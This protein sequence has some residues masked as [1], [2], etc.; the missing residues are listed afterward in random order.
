MPRWRRILA[1]ALAAAI[2]LPLLS[3]CWDRQELE[4]RA[5]ILGMAIDEVNEEAAPDNEHATHLHVPKSLRNHRILVTA[6]IAIPGR[7]PLG[8][9]ESG[10]GKQGGLP[11]WVVK[12]TGYSI[13]DAL[14]NLQQE[15]ADPRSLIHLRIIVVSE[16]I[17]RRGMEDINDYFR[18]NSEVRRSTWIVV[19]D[20][21]ANKLMNVAPPLKRVPTLYL[22]SMIE[23]AVE[24][25]KFPPQFA[26]NFWSAESRIG[27]DEFL[28]Y[29][30]IRQKE[31]ILLKGMALFHGGKMIGHSEPIEIGSYMAIKGL[32][33]GG[34]SVLGD[35]PGIGA[36]MLKSNR[37]IA[38]TKVSIRDGKPHAHIVVHLDTS[39]EEKIDG[40][41]ERY[42]AEDF[43][44]IRK[45]MEKEIT[46]FLLE[47]IRKTQRYRSDPFGFGE[48]FR[49]REPA[50]WNSRIKSKQDW[51][52]EYAGMEFELECKVAIRREGLKLN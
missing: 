22:L 27:Q 14:S 47:F 29:V 31:N 40:E 43:N 17:A 6:Q 39:I 37:R 23:K 19:S 10:G 34:Y 38:E 48:M 25:G 7:V 42:T 50:Y 51:G 11:V 9:G 45:D 1:L 16:K 41:S 5:L 20:I 12:V 46:Y 33:P 36:I 52:R 24:M 35:V 13:D 44:L 32:N 28:P 18:R 15:I 26:G 8:P 30:S 4:N 21:E 49:A 2:A 3:G